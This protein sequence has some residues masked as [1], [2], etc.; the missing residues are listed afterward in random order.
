MSLQ[1]RES[2]I[3]I[4]D[5][6]EIRSRLWAGQ[7]RPG[8]N[9][10]LVE[11]SDICPILRGNSNNRTKDK[12]DRC[13][14][15]G[16][17]KRNLE[18]YDIAEEYRLSFSSFERVPKRTIAQIVRSIARARDV[19]DEDILGPSQCLGISRIRREAYYKIAVERPELSWTVIASKLGGR[20]Y[21]TVLQ[22]ALSYAK[23]NGL[24]RVVRK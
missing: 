7:L 17:I 11:N 12:W 19:S 21:S 9:G 23:E 4:T 2:E 13:I 1:I 20:E 24:Q 8:E 16:R 10:R 22:G 6:K 14:I 3:K 15:R 5:V 18:M